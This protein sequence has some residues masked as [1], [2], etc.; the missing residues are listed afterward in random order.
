MLS[1]CLNC[2][3]NRKLILV[4]KCAACD[5]KKLKFIK[6]QEVIGLLSKLCI[7]TPLIKIPL[8]VNIFF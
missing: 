2:K 7:R 1:N 4:T 6:K 5:N 8:I 3:R